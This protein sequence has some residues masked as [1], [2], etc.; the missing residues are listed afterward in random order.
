[1]QSS[2]SKV[3]IPI[4]YED[5]HIV[6]ECSSANII[7]DVAERFSDLLAKQSNGTCI[8][9]D[10]SQIDSIKGDG[11]ET[12]MQLYEQ[13]QEHSF[14]VGMFRVAFYIQ[15]LLSVLDLSDQLPP[16]ITEDDEK[17]A[18]D[19]L[20]ELAL[21]EPD[22]EDSTLEFE[23]DIP[24]D[25]SVEPFALEDTL[26]TSTAKFNRDELLHPN[27]EQLGEASPV[28][29]ESARCADFLGVDFDDFQAQVQVEE[30]TF[31]I[32]LEGDMAFADTD[33]FSI[34]EV[35]EAVEQQSN[36]SLKDSD[37]APF[38]LMTQRPTEIFPAFSGLEK[39]ALD[40]S[41]SGLE[42]LLAVD[43]DDFKSSISSPM[44]DTPPDGVPAVKDTATDIVDV[45]DFELDYESSDEGQFEVLDPQQ[46]TPF[47]PLM[48]S[49]RGY[50]PVSPM[51]ED[52]SGQNPFAHQA[53]TGSSETKSEAYDQ[54]LTRSEVPLNRMETQ[55]MYVP[56][57]TLLETSKIDDP[58]DSNIPAEI[59]ITEQSSTTSPPAQPIEGFQSVPS[60]TAAPAA[61]TPEQDPN[62][63]GVGDGEDSMLLSDAGNIA[64]IQAI[65]AAEAAKL[66][67]TSPKVAADKAAADKAAADKAAADKAAADKAAADKAAADAMLE[68]QRMSMQGQISTSTQS[69][70]VQA[71]ISESQ[72]MLRLERKK[73]AEERRKF[74][75]ER[76]QFRL[77]T[78]RRK[79][80]E[81]RR[82]FEEE[83]RLHN[84]Q[85]QSSQV[86]PQVSPQ[87]S[88]LASES[89]RIK[90]E[91]EMARE[92]NRQLVMKAANA[93]RERL[94]AELKSLRD[95]EQG[96]LEA[97]AVREAER[98]RLEEQFRL[99]ADAERKRLEAEIH[100]ARE[101]A[102]RKKS[103]PV[104]AVQPGQATPRWG[105][106]QKSVKKSEPSLQLLEGRSGS[107]ERRSTDEVKS[108]EQQTALRASQTIK[109]NELAKRNSI[110][111]QF[112][113]EY[114]I[115]SAL[116]IKILGYL[117]RAGGR[118]QGKIEVSKY[119]DSSQAIVGQIL[120]DFAQAKIIKR[121]RAPRI[122]GGYGYSFSA[123]PKTRNMIMSLLRLSDEGKKWPIV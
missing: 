113:D 75:E 119:V 70:D 112:I 80:E 39:D 84:Q 27:D 106:P 102:R 109:N 94:E 61:S 43:F 35:V 28:D 36:E 9:L 48:T 29:S 1:M 120:D 45:G 104:P 81:E 115:N 65:L 103:G 58:G 78:E 33:K 55:E 46:T 111:Q 30:E 85:I 31:E 57:W 123:S 3:S 76:E 74:D 47:G 53:Y 44:T 59:D 38:G 100:A 67:L 26:E 68:A 101:A 92:A 99:S 71:P 24:E 116:H 105:G 37:E 21:G 63:F 22:D 12:L 96:K 34:L 5:G 40:A 98:K 64:Q 13:G 10:M 122:R 97:E 8:L 91:L 117:K 90:L 118:P 20:K 54:S 4:R 11:L 18:A 41:P 83:R 50:S 25:E 62:Y 56:N 77:A 42:S 121:V 49:E 73:L 110:I 19:C 107:S 93:E 15:Q 16:V 108:I 2:S 114:A 32:N 60:P 79:F 6:V 72:R 7:A 87:V 23:F 86:S 66:G 82:K 69:H 89:Q 95:G 88:S 17:T 51:A 14:S 52:S